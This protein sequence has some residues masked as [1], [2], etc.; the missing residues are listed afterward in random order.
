M[1]HLR[2]ILSLHFKKTRAKTKHS[3]G[4]RRSHYIANATVNTCSAGQA[5]K[6]SA[7]KQDNDSHRQKAHNITM[8]SSILNLRHSTL[9]S[10]QMS[11][12]SLQPGRPILD[13][14]TPQGWKAE[15]T[16]VN[17]IYQNLNLKKHISDLQHLYCLTKAFVY[18][19]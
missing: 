8:F 17:L 16:C 6:D 7:M 3:L 12:P 4:E 13:S 11:Q 15:L 19:F 10:R 14:S 1:Q 18:E 5:H 2:Q 9:F